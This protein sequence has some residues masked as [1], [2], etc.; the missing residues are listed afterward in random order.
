MYVR[1]YVCVC[2]CV[3][4]YIADQQFEQYEA[5]ILFKATNFGLFSDLDMKLQMR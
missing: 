1:T 3:I 4:H 2:V 5:E